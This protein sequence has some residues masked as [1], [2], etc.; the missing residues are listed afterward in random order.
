MSEAISSSN[1]EII[2]ENEQLLKHYADE[3]SRLQADIDSNNAL[4]IKHSKMVLAFALKAGAILLQAKEIAPFGNW[5]NWVAANVKGIGIRTAEN[6]MKLAEKA[7]ETQH[8]AFFEAAESLREAY[9]KFGIITPSKSKSATKKADGKM[10]PEKMKDTDR[11][12]YSAKLNEA[13][14]SA[15]TCAR[16][17]LA[18]ANRVNW[19]LSTWT[20]K[21]NKPRSGDETNYGAALFHALKKWI[22]KREF[23]SSLTY[24]DEVA[25]KAG[26][27]LSEL[28]QTI[29]KANSE[30][31]VTDAIRNYSLELN[32][33][34]TA[35]AELAS[36]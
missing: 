33:Q 17:K 11:A 3:L 21:N 5:E 8:V 24:E 10:T 35:I 15:V 22:A 26:I 34:P 1:E 28:V 2:Q 14:Q 36:A 31:E 4:S 32:P 19:K 25:T 6:Y 30:P 7:A 27:V 23:E 9:I 29:I 20:V 12:K 16:Q 18:D 13:Y